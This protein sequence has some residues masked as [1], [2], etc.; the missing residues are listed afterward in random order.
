[1][2]ENSEDDDDKKL[3]YFPSL[4]ERDRLRKERAKVEEQDNAGKSFTS[5]PAN[6]PFFNTGKIPPFVGL[7]TIGFIIIHAAVALL[8]DSGQVLR[9]YY[10]LGF[11][12][13]NYSGLGFIHEQWGII[14][15]LSPF[16]YGFLHGSWIHL[17]F[18]VVMWVALGTFF[19]REFG[20]KTAIRFFFLCALGGVLF[21]FLVSP[22]STQAVIGASAS[23]S[24]CFAAALVL[25][26]KRGM[27]GPRGRYGIA[28]I[29][30]FWLI[31]MIALGMAG[32]G[33]GENVAWIAHLGGFLTG[34]FYVS[35]KFQRN[36]KFW[37]L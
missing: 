34:L 31:L 29:L 6:V 22:F 24:G 7:V 27:M 30:I 32:G 10:T 4:A 23:I 21:H 28:P 37:T 20:T 25:F 16:T 1:M 11:V 35:W 19:E 5:A 13:V 3:I 36:F 14:Y 9:L 12:P 18:N 2:N 26:Y 33:M 15:L 8:M 17:V